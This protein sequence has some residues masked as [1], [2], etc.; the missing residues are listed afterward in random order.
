MQLP[1]ASSAGG[2]NNADLFVRT[3]D[4]TH[5]TG[6]GGDGSKGVGV[7]DDGESG[8]EL[9]TS[10]NVAVGV[11]VVKFEKISSRTNGIA[12]GRARRW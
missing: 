3:P 12:R 1:D 2:L 4:T 9:P 6:G 10:N 7:S 5:V 8:M 11:V